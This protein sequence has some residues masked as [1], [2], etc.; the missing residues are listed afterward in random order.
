MGKKLTSKQAKAKAKAEAAAKKLN[1]DAPM[2]DEED[3]DTEED[4]S[5]DGL[6]SIKR[7]HVPNEQLSPEEE[8]IL[9]EWFAEHPLFYD[10]T[11]TDFKN[12]G[13]KDRLLS[14]KGKDFKITRAELA[15][16]FKSQRT[17]YGRLNKKKSGQSKSTLTAR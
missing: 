16:W 7:R 14:E 11:E 1:T 4:E 15:V 8:Q 5:D 9:V 6:P 3:T 2:D 17:I 12:R 10:Q 13:K